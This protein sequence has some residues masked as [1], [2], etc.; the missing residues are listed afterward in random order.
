[1]IIEYPPTMGALFVRGLLPNTTYPVAVAN[2]V[3]ACLLVGLADVTEFTATGVVFS[4]GSAVIY[5]D[6]FAVATT[7]ESL[8][9]HDGKVCRNER[10]PRCSGGAV[11]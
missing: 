8:E 3:R 10:P 5:G 9:K 4:D 6:N 1:M 7:K 11:G 2:R